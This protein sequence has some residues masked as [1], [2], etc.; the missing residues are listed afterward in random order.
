MVSLIP[1]QSEREVEIWAS[2]RDR[3]SEGG[4]EAG[5]VLGEGADGE[6]WRAAV[7]Q[8]VRG[9]EG[10]STAWED[11]EPQAVLTAG[12]TPP[13]SDFRSSQK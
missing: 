7:Q 4:Q 3:A 2:L 11:G 13:R 9:C 8:G 5:V 6:N 1:S 12:M 10:V